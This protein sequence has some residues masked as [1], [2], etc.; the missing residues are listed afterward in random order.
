MNNLGISAFWQLQ[1][2]LPVLVDFI[3]RQCCQTNTSRL[4]STAGTCNAQIFQKHWHSYVNVA[5]SPEMQWAG[6]HHDIDDD[7]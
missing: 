3:D 4:A 7:E 5:T 1:G 6:G 2:L